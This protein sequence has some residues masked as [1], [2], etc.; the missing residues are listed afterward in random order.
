MNDVICLSEVKMPLL[1]CKVKKEY[2]PTGSVR[3]ERARFK[4][5]EGERKKE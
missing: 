4:N 5:R 1:A 2:E 3:K